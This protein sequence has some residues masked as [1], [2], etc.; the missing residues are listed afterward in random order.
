MH[1]SQVSFVF[2]L[3]TLPALKL[4]QLVFCLDQAVDF[5]DKVLLRLRDHGLNLMNLLVDN[6]VDLFHVVEHL[7]SLVIKRVKLLLVAL[8]L[9]L[10][11]VHLLA[12]VVFLNFLL[13][14]LQNLLFVVGGL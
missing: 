14:S 11:V 6:L 1:R 5:F 10:P 12:G 2:T 13:D 7:I 3:V 4:L 8:Q 9:D